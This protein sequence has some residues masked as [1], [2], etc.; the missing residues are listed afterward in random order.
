[1]FANLALLPDK[2]VA[3]AL[4]SFSGMRLIIFSHQRIANCIIRRS[5]SGFKKGGKII[6]IPLFLEQ[7]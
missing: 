6:K 3:S 5:N 1:M 4:I 2:N 7:C